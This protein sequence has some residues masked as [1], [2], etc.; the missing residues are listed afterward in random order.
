MTLKEKCC[1]LFFDYVDL[2][3]FLNAKI[4]Y[5]LAGFQVV[6][7]NQISECALVVLFRGMPSRIYSGY[8]GSLHF[9]DYVH[10][11]SIPV[12]E[13]FPSVASLTIISLERPK[14]CH[15]SFTYV[16]GYLPVIPSL[17]KLS[18]P[19]VSRSPV[20]IHLSN[21]KSIEEDAYQTDLILKIKAG[22]INV[23]GAKWDRVQIA[24]RPRSYLSAN[25]LLS[26][27]KI[28]YGLM[29]PY[30]RGKSLS[31]RMWQA[32]IQGCI[33]ISEKNTNL[34]NSPGVFEVDRFDLVP[35]LTDN[36]P[37]DLA[38][39]ATRFWQDQ[40]ATLAKNLHLVL[41]YN[42]LPS[43]IAQARLHLL[44]NHLV[45][46]WNQSFSS[47]VKRTFHSTRKLIRIL[48]TK[49]SNLFV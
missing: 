30:Q 27:V 9:Y 22:M 12:T 34:I 45:F 31:G 18:F 48:S 43:E 4:F 33:V 36:D 40:T 47:I 49:I 6:D 1:F 7:E 17:W 46:V 23:Y 2:D 16:C 13:F 25:F 44:L 15:S 10:E 24:A 38:A 3:V 26:S 11:Y 41:N 29:Y 5:H 28:C 32:P 42:D 20:P 35:S 39:Q 21:Y 37:R 8:T 19:F 14:F